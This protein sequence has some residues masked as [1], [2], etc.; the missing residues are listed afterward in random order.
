[1]AGDN[2]GLR[3][4]GLG[5]SS[6]TVYGTPS[7]EVSNCGIFLYGTIMARDYN[8]LRNSFKMSSSRLSKD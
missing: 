6:P 8:S 1:V 2:S 5:G 4:I 7:T 3:Y